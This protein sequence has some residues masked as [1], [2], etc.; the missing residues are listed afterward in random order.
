MGSCATLNGMRSFY[1][2]GLLAASA[3]GE[4]V[5]N[6]VVDAP[7]P[8]ACV[9]SDGDGVCNSIDK[10]ANG[11]DRQDLDADT[12]P[13][14]CD[15]CPAN[16]DRL[17]AD[18]DTVPDACDVC[19]GFDDTVDVNAN[20]V[21][22]GCDVQ[23]RMINLKVVATNR[24]RGWHNHDPINN[25]YSHTTGNDYTNTGTSGTTV[26]NSYFVFPLT[27]FTAHSIVGVTLELEASAFSTDPTE[28]VS[29][30]DVS[31]VSATLEA[32]GSDAA[33]FTDLQT[34]N[35]YATHT[36]TAAGV[37]SMTLNAQAAADVNAKL[38]NDFAVGVHLDT[39]PTWVIWGTSDDRVARLVVRYLPPTPMP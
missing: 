15:R 18:T 9:D 19:A 25:T 38:G 4:V 8:D 32:D 2:V 10:C 3:C 1:L 13:N 34:G 27:G 33:R 24:W 22:D 11:D 12:V 30:W 17:D 29:V 39:A 21:P 16:D 14:S 28:T 36:F 37:Q 23:T 35:M 26:Y 6:T 20:M 5:D 7:P 31:T